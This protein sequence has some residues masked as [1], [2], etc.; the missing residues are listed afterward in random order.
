MNAAK[1]IEEIKRL[2]KR[3]RW[4]VVAF[5]HRLA[6]EKAQKLKILGDPILRLAIEE[7]KRLPDKEQEEVITFCFSLAK[8]NKQELK[9]IGDPDL[10]QAMERMFKI[11]DAL[12][13]RFGDD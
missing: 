10:Q 1:S 4:E 11:H 9:T 5:C 3:E 2:S 6:K 12:V 13:Q 8:E 7:I